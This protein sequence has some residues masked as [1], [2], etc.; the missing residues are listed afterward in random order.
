MP[1]VHL[2]VLYV[3]LALAA[4]ALVVIGLAYVEQETRIVELEE[5]EQALAE[6][7]GSLDAWVEY[8]YETQQGI[9]GN[10][11]ALYD[12]S[13]GQQTRIAVLEES[14]SVNQAS[15]N[16]IYGWSD[17]VAAYLNSGQQSGATDTDQ[18]L[19]DL[20]RAYYLRDPA[21]IA[22]LSQHLITLSVG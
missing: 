11:N 8:L 13:D 22:R 18:I 15:I 14:V 20:L 1:K 21:A 19:L 7:L 3:G 12:L 5:R 16:S 6:G 10:V 2:A 17:E 4:A 9:Q